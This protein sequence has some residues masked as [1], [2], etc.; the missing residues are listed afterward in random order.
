[1]RILIVTQYFWPENF[2]VNNLVTGLKEKGHQIEVLT[3]IPNYPG[4]SFFP[5]YGLFNRAAEEFHGVPIVRCPLVP[6]GSGGGLRLALNY[7]SFALS[8]SLAALRKCRGKYDVIFIY[9][10][11]PITVALPAILIKKRSSA[12]LVLWVQ[13]LWPESLSATGAVRSPLVLGLVGRLVRFIYQR[14]D[15]ILMQSKG[16]IPAVTGMGYPENRV[17]YFPNSADDSLG[18]HCEDFAGP[19][20]PAGFRVVFAGNIG[21]AQDFE[22]ILQAAERLKSYRDIV[23]VVAGDGRM[24]R[25]L[26]NQVAERYLT[27]TVHLTGMLP[28]ESM[29]GLFAGADVLLVTLGKAPIFS[30]TIPSKI[31]AYLSAA[32]PIIAA[33][34]GEGARI[35]EEAGAGLTCP[36][37]DSEQLANA[38]LTLYNC[39]QQERS[40]MGQRGRHYYEQ[41]FEHNMLLERLEGWMRELA[42]IKDLN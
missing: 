31:Q 33:L 10:P 17:R 36:S 32:K 41:N 7:A 1:M 16:F 29:P 8:A 28:A 38:M 35:V 5:G 37:G 24:R 22:T 3:G 14:C 34:D 25:W 40:V 23:L 15:R 20:L 42:E 9:E 30:M 13:D 2:R 19:A 39:S 12:A 18:S 4:G 11:S 21:A 27:D 26:E 6:R